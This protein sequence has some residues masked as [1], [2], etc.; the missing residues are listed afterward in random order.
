MSQFLTY[1]RLGF[2][3]ISDIQGFDH[4]LFILTLCAV[5]KLSEWK[6]VLVLVTA[7]TIGHSVTLALSALKI[8]LTNA[9]WIELLIPVTIFLTSMGNLQYTKE[10]GKKEK[11]SYQYV[12]ALLFGFVHGMGFSNF[13]NTLMGDSM[14]IT[15][16]LFAFNVGLEIGQLLIVSLFFAFYYVL[17]VWIKFEHRSWIVF[18]SGAGAGVS[19]VL[20]IERL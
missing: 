15:L 10:M 8:I 7:F 1:L 2:D 12:L 4:I 13:F 3:H 14:S 11:V 6:K 5:Y 20:I 19:L 16:P 9:Y 18:F 17:S